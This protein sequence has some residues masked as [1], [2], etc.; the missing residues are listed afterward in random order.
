MD[1][2][3][4]WFPTDHPTNVP[5]LCVCCVDHTQNPITGHSDNGQEIRIADVVWIAKIS[6]ATGICKQPLNQLVIRLW[7]HIAIGRPR[8][9]HIIIDVPSAIQAFQG[10]QSICRAIVE[11]FWDIAIF[12]AETVLAQRC[13]SKEVEGAGLGSRAIGIDWYLRTCWGKVAP[14]LDAISVVIGNGGSKVYT[15]IGQ[16]SVVPIGEN[17]MQHS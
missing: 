13:F 5:C 9:C 10:V 6:N 11:I 16:L 4:T 3:P 12:F 7:R 1:P 14:L 2:G 8:V 17:P 15:I